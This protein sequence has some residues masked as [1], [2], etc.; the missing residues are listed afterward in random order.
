M[1]ESSFPHPIVLQQ[2]SAP[3]P[4][5]LALLFFYAAPARLLTQL[6]ADLMHWSAFAQFA[7]IHNAA[8]KFAFFAVQIGL[9]CAVVIFLGKKYP[10]ALW[11]PKPQLKNRRL[12]T[13]ML[14]LPL[15]LWHFQ[16]WFA[17]ARVFIIVDHQDH[18]TAKQ[19]I[20]SLHHSIWVGMAYGPSLMGVIYD[21]LLSIIMAPV[22]EEMLINGLLANA[23]V[24]SFGVVAAVICTPVCFA[25][26]HVS[27]FGF[28]QHL[29]PIFFMGLTCIVIRFYSGSL[30][31]SIFAH[32]LMNIVILAPK[33]AVAFMHFKFA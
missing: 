20:D 26:A 2:A 12:L 19:I 15:L 31:L 14:V 28:G 32:I 13:A 21:S 23:F 11:L 8:Y 17:M 16:A 22:F 4:H 1:I 24:R 10:T 9:I 18:A 6:T 25:L 3:R 33:W 30:K 27:Q 5:L 7:S 29:I